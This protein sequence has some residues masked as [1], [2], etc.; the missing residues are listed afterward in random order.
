[1]RWRWPS[2]RLCPETAST[3]SLTD[4]F[5]PRRLRRRLASSGDAAVLSGFF[6]GG[7]AAVGLRRAVEL[8]V[9]H[10][11]DAPS[12][13]RVRGLL[14]LDRL[15]GG[16]RPRA[17]GRH[18]SGHIGHLSASRLV[19]RRCGRFGGIS[20]DSTPAVAGL[21]LERDEQVP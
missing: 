5:A 18:T 11:I 4:E 13:P 8:A 12:A 19:S 21:L 2:R 16:A 10:V 20:P 14:P 9:R 7:V 17:I 3:R 1:M 15:L 6:D